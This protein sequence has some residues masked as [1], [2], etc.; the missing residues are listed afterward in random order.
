MASYVLLG[1]VPVMAGWLLLTKPHPSSP[2]GSPPGLLAAG[3]SPAAKTP[4]PSATTSPAPSAGSSDGCPSVVASS[5]GPLDSVPADLTWTLSDQDLVPTS[6]EAG[7]VI[8]E[9]G[10]A[11]CFAHSAEGALIAAVRI[12]AQVM[13]ATPASWPAARQGLAPGPLAEA[14]DAQVTTLLA[15]PPPPADTVTPF[16][17]VAGFKFLSYS[18]ADAVVEIVYRTQGG[19]LYAA[20]ETM[21]WSAGDW[22]LA[23]L[24]PSELSSPQT[25][26]PNLVGY[27]EWPEP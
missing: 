21:L 15:Q 26:V 27:V 11:R 20:D 4:W 14:F 23:L 25:V 17:A 5:T 12:Q 3:T 19:I 24:G 16:A 1:V 8:D 2:G 13:G 22:H 10:V 7:P 6:T 18:G 9:G